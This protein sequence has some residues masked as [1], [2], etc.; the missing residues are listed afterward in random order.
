RGI[1]DVLKEPLL[2]NHIKEETLNAMW[3]AVSKHKKP[4]INY[5]N[6][7]AE[8]FGETKLNSY[9]FWAP[10]AENREQIDYNEAV[11]LVIEHLGGF[12]PKMEKFIQQAFDK[13]WIESEDRPDKLVG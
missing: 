3:K 8:L 5:L 12:G 6:K 1:E 7:K 4:F 11:D 13:G 9:N 2:N 10:I